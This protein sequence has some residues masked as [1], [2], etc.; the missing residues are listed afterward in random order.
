MLPRRFQILLFTLS[1]LTF[2]WF[3]QG[4]GWNQNARFA[5]VR[6]IVEQG[7]FAVDDFMVYRPGVGRLMVRESVKNAEFARD[8]KVYRLCWG[9]DPWDYNMAPVNGKSLDDGAVPV[10][11]GWDTCSGDVGIAPDGHFHP[12]KPPGSPARTPPRAF[13]A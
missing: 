10:V 7:T 6:A 3:H 5:E 9:N 4:G 11:I 2:A 8:G 12:N 1:F 13:A